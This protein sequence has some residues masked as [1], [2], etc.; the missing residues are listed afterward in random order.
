MSQ[1][2]LGSRLAGGARLDDLLN[3]SVDARDLGDERTRR[4]LMTWAMSTFREWSGSLD[5]TG[6]RE[7]QAKWQT[8]A[9]QKFLL[10]L[11]C[12]Y[13]EDQNVFTR[14]M[15]AVQ[16][17]Q[18]F[19]KWGDNVVRQVRLEADAVR[20]ASR[21]DSAG[22]PSQGKRIV[23]LLERVEDELA[24]IKE[25]LD[26]PEDLSVP[27]GWRVNS[28]GIWRVQVDAQGEEHTENICRVPILITGIM[29]DNSGEGSQVILKWRAR[30]AW[31]TYV[32]DRKTVAIARS[33]AELAQYDLPVSSQSAPQLVAWL[34]AFL[35][36]NDSSIPEARVSAH[37][38]WQGTNDF[39]WGRNRITVDG[40]ESASLDGKWDASGLHLN[41]HRPGAASIASGY[42]ENGSWEEWKALVKNLTPHPRFG[43]MLYASIAAP[44]LRV[45]PEA[46]NFVVDL[47]GETSR[48]KTTALRLATSVWG[49]PS[50]RDGGLIWSWDATPTWIERTA[51][52]C[53]DLPLVL[54]DSK[55]AKAE[56]VSGI[57]YAVAQGVGRGRGTIAG[58]QEMT[59][60]R[61]V[62][63]STGEAPLT[64]YAT[65][66]GASARILSLWG[67][68]FRPDGADHGRIA[69]SIAR[70]CH[71]NY[72]H[73]GPRIVQML[74]DPDVQAACK[75]EYYT[76]VDKWAT[77]MKSSPV[78]ARLAQ[79][80]GVLSVAEFLYLRAGM[81]AFI[82]TPLA[83]AFSV[84]RTS[85]LASDRA[86]S[87]M[88]DL[89]NWAMSET[90]Q[91][92]ARGDELEPPLT[93]YG[94]WGGYGEDGR[95]WDTCYVVYRIARDQ[96]TKM[97]Y[98]AAAVISTW[99]E[100]RWLIID[101]NSS[102]PTKTASMPR[103][104]MTARFLALT[105][106][107][108]D[109]AHTLHEQDIARE[110][111][112]DRKRMEEARDLEERG[113]WG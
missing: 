85:I 4:K 93:C 6:A 104:R 99:R 38:G 18:G 110:I 45:L 7:A 91:H 64:H 107:G 19:R 52:M 53:S 57:V 11:A 108:Y 56:R 30:G 36:A 42:R 16:A 87:A 24:D 81:P 94:K 63:I 67:S 31:R 112:E 59:K 69:R 39:L 95:S 46:P 58:Q 72:G 5:S 62:L 89:V 27:V 88:I 25:G 74:M 76:A 47:A 14:D 1:P 49:N 77:L 80:L 21:R 51:S 37:L 48:G 35:V 71:E 78:G 82:D 55:R 65:E 32:T 111:A 105:R 73:L 103:T 13:V 102:S 106:G 100:R 34:E 15:L 9:T 113:L 84:L 3:Q 70:I 86:A 12:Q 33:L 43:L 68:P 75:A 61:T 54:D 8:I 10:G 66:G 96:L 20:R 40:V 90:P 28:G 98:D 109:G 50:E 26:L 44:I 22:K 97:G 79:Y 60:W 29:R 92:I 101:T 41:T 23:S 17:R 2:D 83:E